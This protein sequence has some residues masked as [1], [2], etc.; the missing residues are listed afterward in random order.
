MWFS[1]KMRLLYLTLYLKRPPTSSS[2]KGCKNITNSPSEKSL[3]VHISTEL[4]LFYPFPRITTRNFWS[5]RQTSQ[6]KSRRTQVMNSTPTTLNPL[7]IMVSHKKSFCTYNLLNVRTIQKKQR[8]SPRNW[9][10]PYPLW[11]F[12]LILILWYLHHMQGNT[13][14]PS[15][16]L[17]IS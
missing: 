15:Q 6:L 3:R 11:S 17:L 5:K 12:I 2:Y 8:R 4:S 7:T 10:C 9:Q 1:S 16:S 14:K 13:G